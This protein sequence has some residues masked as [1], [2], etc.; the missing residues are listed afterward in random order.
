MPPCPVRERPVRRAERWRFVAVNAEADEVT[1]ERFAVRAFPTLIYFKQ[2][3]EAFRM[4]G[5]A[6]LAAIVDK[7]DELER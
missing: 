4:A 7:L 2:G 3:E 5:S 1:A 6:S